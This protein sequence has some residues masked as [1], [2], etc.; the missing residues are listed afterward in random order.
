MDHFSYEVS[1]KEKVR[2]FQEEG[3]RNQAVH[4]SGAPKLDPLRDLPKLILGLLGIL[5][6]LELLLR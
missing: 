5:G 2:G 4:R 1:G 3:L 6:I